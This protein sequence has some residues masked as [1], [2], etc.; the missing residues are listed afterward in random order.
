MAD[1][2]HLLKIGLE[3]GDEHQQDDANFCQVRDEG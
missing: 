2:T 3:A 1:T